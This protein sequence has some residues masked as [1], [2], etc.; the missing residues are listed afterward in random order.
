M[1]FLIDFFPAIIFLIV[2]KWQGI[3]VATA[4]LIAA[5]FIQIAVTW[6]W[7][8]Q[9]KKIHL[10]TAVAVL[11]FGGFTIYFQNE[12]F[13]KWKPTVVY[14]LFATAFSASA[15][16]GKR[17]TLTERMLGAAAR[18][19]ARQWQ[20]LNLAW[21]GFF[22]FTAALN[23]YVAYQFSTETWVTFKVIGLILLTLVFLAAQIFYLYKA[24]FLVADES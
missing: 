13:I 12:W 10:I 11:I 8:K 9:I 20:Q 19:P 21:I 4:T 5:T 6:T 18:M 17:V 23:I 24:G 1:D 16:F 3:Y 2:F 7:K 15:I 22:L 14:L